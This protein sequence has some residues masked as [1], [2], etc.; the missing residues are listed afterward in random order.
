MDDGMIMTVEMM[1]MMQV[2]KA[3][4]TQAV[5]SGREEK[6]GGGEEEGGGGRDGSTTF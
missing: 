1:M 3:K 5:L 2:D 4:Y 6:R